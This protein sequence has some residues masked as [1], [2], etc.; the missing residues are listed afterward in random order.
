MAQYI[1]FSATLFCVVFFGFLV[2][3]ARKLDQNEIEKNASRIKGG[4]LSVIRGEAEVHH[5]WM[6]DARV[7][8]GMVYNKRKNRLEV[9]GRISL[10]A[11]R[12]MFGK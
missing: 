2:F 1:L 5:D 11:S 10:E 3:L 12:S 4:L 6:P 8:G 7:K 9:S